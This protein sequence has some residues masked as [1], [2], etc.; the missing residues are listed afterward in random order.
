MTETIK[1]LGS[2]IGNFVKEKSKIVGLFHE[3][4]RKEPHDEEEQYSEMLYELP[5]GKYYHL[6]IVHSDED[7]LQASAICGE[8][9][10]RFLLK[11]MLPCQ[12]GG[13]SFSIMFEIQDKMSKIANVLLLLSPAFLKYEW[14][15]IV[16]NNIVLMFHDSNFNSKVIP[17]ILR[18]IDAGCDLP[19]LLRHY[20]CIDA[21]KENDCCAKI[22]EAIYHTG[23][24]TKSY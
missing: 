7:S 13:S 8:L 14:S 21:Q 23:K 17:V 1:R 20:V 16:I 4:T 3:N 22:I 24:H 5:P 12:H 10:S 19:L 11:C 15:D 6:Y 18:D 2:I 9:E